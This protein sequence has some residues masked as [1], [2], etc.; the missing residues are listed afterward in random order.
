MPPAL[1][2]IADDHDDN[3]ELLRVLLAEAGYGVREARDG[4]E[5]VE[6]ARAGEFALALVDLSMPQRDGW[7][8]LRALRAD[9]RTRRLPCV[10]VTAFAGESDRQR[11]LA[12]GFD[13]YISKP[14]RAKDLLDLVARL[15]DGRGDAHQRA[16]D[17]V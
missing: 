10:A 1:I 7:D 14:Y 12:A 4:Q 17:D 8:V 3:R 16:T 5:C 9:E 13:A 11:A 6:A 2:L 15:L